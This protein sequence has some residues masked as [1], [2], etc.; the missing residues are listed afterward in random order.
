M[1]LLFIEF[2]DAFRVNV[3]ICELVEVERR[4]LKATGELFLSE[5]PS[6]DV[7]LIFFSKINK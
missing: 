4:I 6:K 3:L 5:E 2:L 1:I 7:D